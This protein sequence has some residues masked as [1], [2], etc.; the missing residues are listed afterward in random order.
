MGLEMFS[1][2]LI[3]F[4]IKFIQNPEKELSEGIL[5]ASLFILMEAISNISS[6]QKMF[7]QMQ[8]GMKAS[9]AVRAMIYRKSL[10]ITPSTN[11][12]FNSGEII[13]FIQND[14]QKI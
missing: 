9:N 4:F 8:L 3:K 6:V 5:W 1:P 10:R 14:S 7:I 13:N 11:K 2:F 12:Y